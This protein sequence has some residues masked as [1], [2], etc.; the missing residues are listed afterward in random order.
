M[1]LNETVSFLR[2]DEARQGRWAHLTEGIESEYQRKVLE[3]LLDNAKALAERRLIGARWDEQ[4][5]TDDI[6]AFNRVAYPLI[7]RI[8][9][10][11]VANELV[12]IQ[13]TQLPVTLVFFL[14]FVYG[15]NLA[16]TVAGDRNDYEAG[17]FNR[18]Y[19]SGAVRGEEVGTGTGTET[20]FQLDWYPVREG[21]VVIYVDG[22]PS[23]DVTIDHATGAITFGTAPDDGA[24]ITADYNLV[25][26]GLGSQGNAQIPELELEMSSAQVGVE[27]KKLKAKWTIE[28]S[29]DLA[30]YHGLSAEG[31]M[32]RALAR[33]IR[34]EIDRMIIEDLYTHASAANVNWDSTVPA[35]TKQSEH[36]ET[37]IHAIGDV[38]NEIYKKRL[39]HANF[40]VCAPDTINMLDKINAFRL[41]QGA[42]TDGKVRTATISSGPNVMGTLSNRYRV[43]VDPT[44]P[45]NKVLVGYKG[46]DWTDTGYVYAPYVAF[47]TQTFIDPNDM[48]PRKGLMT[49]FGRHLVNGD[50]YGTVTIL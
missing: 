48:I 3:T 46:E 50:F 2:E 21:S 9:P 31:E 15:T 44:F 42:A 25:M 43:I 6:A 12:S 37:L 19:A 26:E 32:V 10:E 1:L 40:V 22:V 27:S 28:A 17:K 11:L 20:D 41:T 35:D 34:Q 36:Y 16:P 23:N 47:Q 13:P 29:Q 14:D 38:S 7:R 18:L 33:E 45:T 4:T 39:R 8:Y 30:A 24:A 49:R 5:T